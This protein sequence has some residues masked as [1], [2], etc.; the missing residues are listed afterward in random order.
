MTT[1]PAWPL[2]RFVDAQAPVYAQVLAELDAGAKA[3]HWMWFI[4]PQLRELGRSGTA[5]H[6]G[7]AGLGEASAYAAHPLLGA[8]LADCSRRVL[9]HAGVRS[10][11]HIFGAVDAM[12][13]RSC[14]TLFDRAAPAAGPWQAVLDAFYA[15]RRDDAT[16][17]LVASA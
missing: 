5:R 11:Q 6:Y 7:L 12:K 16:T 8:R 15:G 2:Q 9:R 13:L 3:S 1:A 10:A 4:F 17:A 14:M